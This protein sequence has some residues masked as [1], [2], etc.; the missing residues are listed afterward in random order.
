MRAPMAFHAI[1]SSNAPTAKSKIRR[2]PSI[3]P[4]LA[5]SVL[6]PL[7]AM[8]LMARRPHFSIEERLRRDALTHVAGPGLASQSSID[9]RMLPSLQP[10]DHAPGFTALGTQPCP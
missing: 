5:A 6:S 9:F 3:T 4:A 1:L 7:A 2:A 10:A 8:V